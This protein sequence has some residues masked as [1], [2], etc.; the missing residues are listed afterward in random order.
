MADES[1]LA[2]GGVERIG[3]PKSKCFVE[4]AASVTIRKSQRKI[5]QW[6]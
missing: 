6:P 1:V 2:R 4:V 5:T 3:S